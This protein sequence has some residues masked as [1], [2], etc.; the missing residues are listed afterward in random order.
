MRAFREAAFVRVCRRVSAR[1]YLEETSFQC[2]RVRVHRCVCC[3]RVP[4]CA[5]SAL[6]SPRSLALACLAGLFAVMVVV[7]LLLL[8]RRRRRLLPL[9]P[10]FHAPSASPCCRGCFCSGAT[11]AA[12]AAAAARGGGGGGAAAAS[13]GGPAS[14]SLA[15]QEDGG[16]TKAASGPTAS[17]SSN[18]FASGANQNSGNV[19]TGRPST[20]VHAPP[21]GKSSFMFG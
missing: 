5:G 18:S 3:V 13:G 19:M 15:W 10:S 20:R 1:A 16:A 14:I 6:P 4:V 8:R 12:A 9:L 17:S 2:A 11:S 21:G 7:L